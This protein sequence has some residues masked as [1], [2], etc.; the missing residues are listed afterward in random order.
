[1]DKI[2]SIKNTVLLCLFFVSSTIILRLASA[3]SQ[4]KLPTE[5][6]IE[7]SGHTIYLEVAKTLQQKE[8]GLMYRKTLLSN[9]GMLFI[10]QPPIKVNFWMKN[11]YIPLDIIFLRDIQVKKIISNIPPCQR[12]PCPT[13]GT[14]TETDQVIEINAG[15]ASK[16]DLKVGNFV[17]IQ[18]LK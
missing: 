9:R 18:Y 6:L 10:F 2:L 3:K 13:Y 16:L 1:M 4:Q 5:A 8:I 12:K 7:V 17:Q 11:T 15:Q 14:D